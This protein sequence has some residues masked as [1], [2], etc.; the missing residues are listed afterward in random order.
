VPD[1]VA[2]RQLGR[3]EFGDGLR[4]VPPPA[5]A[6]GAPGPA[7][8]AEP[9]AT[10]A[11]FSLSKEEF[12]K[13]REAGEKA[14]GVVARAP[15]ADKELRAQTGAAGVRAAE[16]LMRLKDAKA[17]DGRTRASGIRVAGAKTFYLVEGCWTDKDLNDKAEQ[18][19]VKF[20][21][22]AYLAVVEAAPAE[23]KAWIILGDKVS[24]MLPGGKC[25]V[26]SDEGAEKLTK[27]E[28]KA[29]FAK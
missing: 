14:Q 25:L 15:L 2:G 1:E 24:L 17:D 18:V 23:F 12:K 9:A 11:D 28:A 10:R 6:P 3:G 22:D 8:P 20:G 5:V 29:L 4:N 13:V 16:E 26:I 7:K 27:E 21:S 19:K